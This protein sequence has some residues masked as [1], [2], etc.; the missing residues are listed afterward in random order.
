MCGVQ[1]CTGGAR[2]DEVDFE[3]LGNASGEPYLLHTNIFSDGRGGREQQ[4]TS[5]PLCK[6]PTYG[7]W[8][9][10]YF[11]ADALPQAGW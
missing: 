5:H 7:S 1:I 3:L 6:R 10:V 4:P 11:A 9:T 8:E 2:H